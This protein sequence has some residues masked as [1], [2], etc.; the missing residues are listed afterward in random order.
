MNDCAE[1]QTKICKAHINDCY[2]H[3]ATSLNRCRSAEQSTLK[4]NIINMLDKT[5]L[6]I[7][8]KYKEENNSVEESEKDSNAD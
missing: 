4:R 8:G 1:S 5:K 6:L 2:M 7:E 3:L